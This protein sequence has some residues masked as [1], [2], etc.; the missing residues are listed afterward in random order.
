MA[1]YC[2]ERTE[3]PIDVEELAQAMKS[4]IDPTRS[5]TYRKGSS[6]GWRSRFTDEHRRLFDEVAGDL[7]R[8]YGFE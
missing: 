8:Q 6:G 5:H 1:Q 7:L 4:S 2:A 3:T